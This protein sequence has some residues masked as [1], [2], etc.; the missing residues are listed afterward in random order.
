MF[1]QTIELIAKHIT[2]VIAFPFELIMTGIEKYIKLLCTN[3]TVYKVHASITV[4]TMLVI[5]LIQVFNYF[6]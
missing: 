4:G 2:T 6:S 5:T 1:Q 3:E